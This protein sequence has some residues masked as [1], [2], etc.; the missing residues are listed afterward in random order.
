V[1]MDT[2]LLVSLLLVLGIGVLLR[3]VTARFE[4]RHLAFAW[5]FLCRPGE[6]DDNSTIR[7]TMIDR[8]VV[9]LSAARLA[10]LA[11]VLMVAPPLIILCDVVLRRIAPDFVANSP[12]LAEVLSLS[13]IAAIVGL[14][15]GI[16]NVAHMR[17]FYDPA[18][19]STRDG[20]PPWLAEKNRAIPALV[21]T[22]GILW[23]WVL[24]GGEWFSSRLIPNRQQAYLVE[25]DH[26]ILLA[27]GEEELGA[28]RADKSAADTGESREKRLE[29]EMVRAIQR[30]DR[31]LV[32]EVM[33]PLNNVTA[34]SLVNLTPEKFLAVARK[35]GYTRFPCYYDQITNLIGYLYV[36]D[37]LE[38]AVPPTDFR[39]LVHTAPFIPEIARV[40]EALQEMLRLRSQIVICFDEFGGCSGLLSREDIIEELTGEI[41]DEYDRPE[42]I[43]LEKKR[44][45]WVADA[46]IDLDDLAE[47]VGLVL[48]KDNCDTLAGF[49]YRR[50]G[51]V[52]R[53][54]ESI[55]EQDWQIEV[56]QLDRHRI[57]KVR[58][59]PPGDFIPSPDS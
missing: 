48:E 21:A 43:K 3:L 52:P 31:T 51:R 49:I 6:D 14:L 33:R 30:M 55:D 39:K 36:H 22:G 8:T 26:Q 17:G 53:R 46:S 32:R 41:M 16:F 45:H 58:L 13:G 59:T 27:V 9:A 56:L 40:D 57:R 42:G 34:V 18:R 28:A 24:R 5:D 29:R 47:A 38:T 19:P 2:P 15:F 20:L 1:A 44:D 4:A 12:T 54:G 35:K 7:E 37:F 11:S 10:R 23:D 50:L 25:R